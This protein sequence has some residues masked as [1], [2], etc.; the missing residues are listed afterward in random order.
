MDFVFMAAGP[1]LPASVQI[2]IIELNLDSDTNRHIDENRAEANRL[3][4]WLYDHL[5][6]ATTREVIDRLKDMQ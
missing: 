6:L 5:T 3:A 1:G 2:T 4:C